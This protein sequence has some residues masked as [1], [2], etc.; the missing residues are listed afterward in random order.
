M[1]LAADAGGADCQTAT[2]PEFETGHLAARDFRFKP[3]FW[4]LTAFVC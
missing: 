2:H 3:L 4:R 1:Q